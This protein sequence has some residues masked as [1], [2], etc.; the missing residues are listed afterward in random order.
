MMEWGSLLDAKARLNRLVNSTSKPPIPSSSIEK[1]A[2]KTF[3]LA[4]LVDFSLI[5]CSPLAK[6]SIVV[7]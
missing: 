5:C 3:F 7:Y 2:V 6:V 1:L 4:F